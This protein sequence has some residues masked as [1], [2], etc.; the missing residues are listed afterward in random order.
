MF[1]PMKRELAALLATAVVAASAAALGAADA[2][3]GT[4][5]QIVPAGTFSA[6]DGRG[7][8]KAGDKAAMQQIVDRTRDYH[9]ANDIV[10]DYD[11]QSIF[12]AKDGVGGTAP[13]A[14]WV[15]ELQVRD[16][17]IYGRVEWTEKAAAAIRAGEY[18]Y[19]SPVIPHRKSDGQIVILLNAAL[20]NN[21]ALNIDTVAAGAVFP[22]AASTEGTDMEKILA[23]LGLA[24]GTG[25]DA[26]LSAINALTT[27]STAIAKALGLKEDAKQADILAAVN[28]SIADRK[29]FAKAVGLKEDA[30]QKDVVDTVQAAMKAGNPDPEK[31]VPVA[32]MTEVR[33]EL[34][35]VKDDRLAEK[36]ENAVT[37]AM[38]AGKL[39]P[40]LK[41]WGLD[42]YKKDPAQFEKF[43]GSA[44]VLT[45]PQLKVPKKD[46]ETALD[47]PVALSA[48]AGAYQKKLA[49]AGQTIDFA[50]AVMAVKEGKK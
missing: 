42:L 5:I 30:A 25:E 4:W 49:D 21:P 12:G 13:A 27:S 14:G 33:D 39:A 19:L 20:T 45:E 2:A 43:I 36:A 11:H 23:A 24:K 28:S 31:W 50:Q 17:G 48:A 22:F 47:D 3:S 10:V 18:K 16:G 29:A 9:G 26:V 8:F 38:T 7:P 32:A 35:K 34:K 40:A 41:D 15:K 6:R 46:E 37:A 1:R 44:P